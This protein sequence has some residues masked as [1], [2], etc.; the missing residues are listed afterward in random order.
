MSMT[1]ENPEFD[2]LMEEVRREDSHS[3]EEYREWAE[4]RAKEELKETIN[5][6]QGTTQKE[7]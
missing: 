4:M 6:P 2:R 3:Y 1:K 5:P 7:R